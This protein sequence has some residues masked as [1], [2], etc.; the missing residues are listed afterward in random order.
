MKILLFV[1]ILLYW[2]FIAYLP[3]AMIESADAIRILIGCPERGECYNKGW[4]IAE[5]LYIFSI[6]SALAIWP[7]VAWQV[8]RFTK[9]IRMALSNKA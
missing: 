4:W 8:I 6:G 2:L 7:F 3:I 1:A 5:R 9:S